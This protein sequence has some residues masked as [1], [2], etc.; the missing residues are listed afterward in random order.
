MSDIILPVCWW[1]H[2][3]IYSFILSKLVNLQNS[4]PFCSITW[5]ESTFLR[6]RAN[7]RYRNHGE[8]FWRNSVGHKHL[9]T[10]PFFR[11]SAEFLKYVFLF[12]FL[13]EKS[14]VGLFHETVFSCIMTTDLYI[15]ITFLYFVLLS[16]HWLIIC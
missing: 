3:S 11:Q 2:T 8:K 4:G 9:G 5:T 15:K 16:S 14:I 10:G 6:D 13:V 1:W 7:T 12:Y